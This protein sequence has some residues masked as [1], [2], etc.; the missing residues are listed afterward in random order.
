MYIS[1]L[2]HHR[3]ASGERLYFV[4]ISIPYVLIRSVRGSSRN[5][6]GVFGRFFAREQVARTHGRISVR[7]SSN[8]TAP[9]G[10]LCAR[11][12]CTYAHRLFVK[13]GSRS[14]RAQCCCDSSR[15]VALFRAR[16][17]WI[18][19]PRWGVGVKFASDTLNLARFSGRR[20]GETSLWSWRRTPWISLKIVRG[21]NGHRESQAERFVLIRRL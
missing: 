5:C 9:D 7:N 17:E 10:H 16:V 12:T 15:S 21:L 4:L 6:F 13:V 8:S 19:E 18:L 2:N 1:L 11:G 20:L 14:R 3:W